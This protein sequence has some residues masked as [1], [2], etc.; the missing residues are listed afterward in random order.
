MKKSKIDRV[1]IHTE[2]T[3][4][5]EGLDREGNVVSAIVTSATYQDNCIWTMVVEAAR[6]SRFS[7]DQ[8]ANY[9]QTGWI[10]YIIVP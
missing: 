9:R 4:V 2:M 10:R 3:I 8:N 5:M 1:A 6:R 7:M